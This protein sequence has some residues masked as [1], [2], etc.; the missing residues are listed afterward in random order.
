MRSCICCRSVKEKREL[1]RFVLSPSN[2]LV[3][4]YNNKLPGR[5]CYLCP[6]RSCIEKALKTRAFSKTFKCDVQAGPIEALTGAISDRIAKQVQ[7]FFSLSLRSRKI[8]LGTDAVEGKLKK[9]SICLI[10]LESVMSDSQKESWKRRSLGMSLPLRVVP[11]AI[12][13]EALAGNRKVFGVTDEEIGAQL[14]KE[15][16]RFEKINAC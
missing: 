12:D 11:D 9:R 6:D 7:A 4:D 3:L 13:L 5:G 1:L 10:L 8:L 14:I 2:V 15:L 16:D